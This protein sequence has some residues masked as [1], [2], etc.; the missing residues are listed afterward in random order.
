MI[1]NDPERERETPE[2][3]VRVTGRNGEI[4]RAYVR[5]TTHEALAK[6]HNISRQRI[7]QII[8]QVQESI[9]AETREELVRKEV[10]L[11]TT[12]RQ[13]ILEEIYDAAPVPVTAGKDG[14]YVQ[15]PVTGEYVRDHSGRI[16]GATMALKISESLR[17]M[18][19]TDAAQKVDVNVGEEAASQE[20][21]AEARAFLERHEGTEE[22][23]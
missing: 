21:A 14:N 19:G 22:A 2:E 5:G 9:P 7:G 12:L 16:A 15:D 13:E 17:R 1:N 11:W 23:S 10:D 3:T 6:V 8:R 18:L 4:W 20:G